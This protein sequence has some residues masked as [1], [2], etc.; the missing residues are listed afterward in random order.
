MNLA[1][2]L[3]RRADYILGDLFGRRFHPILKVFKMHNG[4]DIKTYG[5]NWPIYSLEHG[6]VIAVGYGK[7]AGNYVKINYPRLGL[8]IELFHLLS[9][10]V[11]KGDRLSSSTLLGYVGTTGGSTGVHLHIGVKRIGSINYIDPMSVD[12]MTPEYEPLVEDGSLGPKTLYKLQLIYNQYPDCRIDGQ[13]N[14]DLIFKFKP[15][16]IFG[17]KGSLLIKS[18]QKDLGC[19]VD[20]HCGPETIRFMQRAT[21]TPVTGKF[22]KVNDPTIL[23]VQRR[24]N[25]KERLWG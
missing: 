11:K 15:F 4:V 1:T 6:I 7:S 19:T 5:K 16:I 10:N 17:V 20:G 25:S 23:E 12:Y 3:L 9:Y 14:A 8:M 24:I 22:L 13:R 21:N 2:Q 18:I